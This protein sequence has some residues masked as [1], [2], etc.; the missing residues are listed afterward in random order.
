MEV[1]QAEMQQLQRLSPPPLVE[2]IIYDDQTCERWSLSAKV[3]SA[4][5]QR[6]NNDAV[7]ISA[8]TKRVCLMK[9]SVVAK[10]STTSNNLTGLFRHNTITASRS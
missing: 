9:H 2:L 5:M 7:V 3:I 1:C 4:A 8:A 6:S 10:Q